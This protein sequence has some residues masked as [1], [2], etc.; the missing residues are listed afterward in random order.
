LLLLILWYSLQA[1]YC[2]LIIQCEKVAKVENWGDG[3]T[4]SGM[5][6]ITSL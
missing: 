2:T 3:P 5:F 6:Q 4:L 1:T